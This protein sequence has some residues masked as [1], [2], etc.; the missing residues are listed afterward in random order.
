M[1]LSQNEQVLLFGGVA[2]AAIG[3]LIW[4]QARDKPVDPADAA[5]KEALKNKG[6]TKEGNV[7][8]DKPTVSVSGAP[9]QRITP[10]A[11][12]ESLYNPLERA[13][14]NA[15]IWNA[16]P[17][18]EYSPIIPDNQPQKTGSPVMQDT[19]GNFFE[20][21]THVEVFNEIK[22]RVWGWFN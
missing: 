5:H 3:G 22:D 19:E 12:P 16:A 21:D 6:L 1:A 4:W 14:V 20:W 10:T 7:K 13:A 2:A 9:E 15:G 8:S 18:A 11:K 17:K